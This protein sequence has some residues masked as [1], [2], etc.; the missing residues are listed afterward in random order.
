[1][2]RSLGA[3][4][5]ATYQ[6]AFLIYNPNAGKLNRTR[7]NLLQRTIE[8]LKTEGHN[9]TSL[10]TTGPRVAATMA[11]ECI[12]KGAD[13]ILA[14]GG[15]GT[16]NEIANGM[17]GL[18]TPLAILP[19]GTANV[20]AVELGIG[21][22]MPKAARNI[23]TLLP[24]RIGVGL[25]ENQ[26][27]QRH[28][29]LM[30]GAGLDALI[31]YNIDAKLKA[32]LGKVAYWVAGFSRLGK[33]MPEFEVRIDGEDLRCSFALISRVRN[34]GGDLWIA[35]NASLLSDKFEVVLF[36]GSNSL[37]YMKYLMG[38]VTGRLGRMRGVRLIHTTSV[39]VQCASDPR[40]Y[41]Q[42]DGEFAGR[43]PVR[44][45]MVPNSLT[46]L[47]PEAFYR[48]HTHG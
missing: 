39:E 35:R 23:S 41:V 46:L 34:Y 47:M 38:V 10:A 40:I 48:K 24:V 11:R 14:A 16:I 43:L 30:A 7:D 29:V 42:I 36:Q 1:M 32:S 2:V 44:F 31:V 12:D 9:V 33:P 8:G 19:G 28:F 26:T 22:D 17:V 4:A 3:S 13:L 27:E 21:V 6:N 20:L 37:P 25:L 15:D 45:S 18:D 5:I